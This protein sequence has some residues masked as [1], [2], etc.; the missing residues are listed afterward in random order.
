[1]QFQSIATFNF[2]LARIV[3]KVIFFI[4][5]LRQWSLRLISEFPDNH[6]CFDFKV[7]WQS[8]LDQNRCLK[9][10]AKALRML[11]VFLINNGVLFAMIEESL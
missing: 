8:V 6:I 3:L 5:L 9:V 1:M 7:T 2:E 11:V 4:S 10:D